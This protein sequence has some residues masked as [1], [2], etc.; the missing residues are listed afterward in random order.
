MLQYDVSL[1]RPAVQLIGTT[2]GGV[3]ETQAPHQIMPGLN[4]LHAV[5]PNSTKCFISGTCGS[6][7]MQRMVFEQLLAQRAKAPLILRDM[8]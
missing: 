5:G 2:D 7:R 3:H 8:E 6:N 1:G 4:P